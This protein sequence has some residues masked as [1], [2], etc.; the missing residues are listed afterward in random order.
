[1]AYTG[2]TIETTVEDVTLSS[3]AIPA[4]P[5]YDSETVFDAAFYTERQ[6][7]NNELAGTTINLTV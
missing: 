7:S 3:H 4:Y 5:E 6:D 2:L 1:M